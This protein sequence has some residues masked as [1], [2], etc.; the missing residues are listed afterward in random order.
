M[1]A[2]L[3]SGDKLVVAFRGLA[4]ERRGVVK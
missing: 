1:Q 3:E 2:V 4:D